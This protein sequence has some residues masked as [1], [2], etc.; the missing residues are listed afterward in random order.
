MTQVDNYAKNW[1]ITFHSKEDYELFMDNESLTSRFLKI[2]EPTIN[3]EKYVVNL[4]S[5]KR[6]WK[7]TLEHL[8]TD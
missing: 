8:M 2:G 3:D 1:I 5:E 7:S 4:L 6:I